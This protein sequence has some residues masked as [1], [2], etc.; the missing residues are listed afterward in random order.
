MRRPIKKDGKFKKLPMGVDVFVHEEQE[1]AYLL[2]HRIEI[3]RLDNGAILA[4]GNEEAENQTYADVNIQFPVGSYY[5]VPHKSGITHLHE[6]LISN[7]PNISAKRCEGNYS[8]YTNS[9]SLGIMVWGIANPKVNN[10]GFWP[11]MESVSKMLTGP[12]NI[13]KERLE[14]EKEVV[15]SEE[16]GYQGDPQRLVGRAFNQILRSETDPENYF[17]SGVEDK[18]RALS[19]SQVEKHHFRTLIPKDLEATVI[20]TGSSLIGTK[21]EKMLEN[22]LNRME[23]HGLEPKKVDEVKLSQLNSSFKTGQIY[24]FDYGLRTNLVNLYYLWSFPYI[25]FSSSS[26]ADTRVFGFAYQKM[27]EFFRASGLGY[28]SEPIEITLGDH[29]LVKGFRLTMTK[30]GDSVDFAKTLLPSLLNKTFGIFKETNF[31]QINELNRLRI[32]AVPVRVGARVNFAL[33]GLREY[34]RIIDNDKV[35]KHSEQVTASD[36][37]DSLGKF[38]SISPAIFA[39]G[40]LS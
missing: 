9:R 6:H 33:F 8:A 28:Q 32:K 20:T 4:L 27:Y 29:T 34:G 3:Q 35:F 7:E 24:K 5:E 19:L 10:Y 2:A 38:M 36:L 26:F 31:D 17:I 21:T 12:F 14:S 15:I 23:N 39:I 22:T 1:E 16:K 30:R 40:D 11:V 37:R 13:S 18:V 25:P